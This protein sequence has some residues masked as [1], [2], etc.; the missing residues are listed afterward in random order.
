MELLG[1]DVGGTGI[2][3]AI[4]NTVTGQLVSKRKR[5]STP[6]P[7]NPQLVIE[8]IV[9]LIQFFD[10]KKNIGCGFP[11]VIQK[12]VV[13]TASNIDRQWIGLNAADLLTRA[14]GCPTYV[15]NDADAAGQALRTD[16]F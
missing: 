14:S 6:R 9:E 15:I 4:I 12:G 11:S 2:K 13:R 10:W 8:T 5:L 1:I 7:A 16:R 3:G